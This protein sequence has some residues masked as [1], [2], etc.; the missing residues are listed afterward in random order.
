[1]WTSVLIPLAFVFAMF[2]STRMFTTSVCCE[3]HDF[4]V[5]GF[6]YMIRAHDC[7]SIAFTSNGSPACDLG[8]RDSVVLLGPQVLTHFSLVMSLP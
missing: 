5:C 6:H 8:M 1:M 7:V 2:A 3:G 4:I